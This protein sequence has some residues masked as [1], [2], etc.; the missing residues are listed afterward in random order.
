MARREVSDEERRRAVEDYRVEVQQW[1]WVARRNFRWSVAGACVLL[2]LL[3]LFAL[4]DSRA[5]LAGNL[6]MLV[7]GL[8]GATTFFLKDW[9]LLAFAFLGAVGGLVWVLV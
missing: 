9:R 2:G 5:D 1:Q 4:F 8:L 3:G 7:G 6:L